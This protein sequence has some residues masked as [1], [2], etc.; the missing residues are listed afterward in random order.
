V[1]SFLYNSEI[2]SKKLIRK[3]S[4][5]NQIFEIFFVQMGAVTPKIEPFEPEEKKKKKIRSSSGK[6]QIG[7]TIL[8]YRLDKCFSVIFHP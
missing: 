1:A 7:K 2:R 4:A 8:L 5:K 6:N 3:I